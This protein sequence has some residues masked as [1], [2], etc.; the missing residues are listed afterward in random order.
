MNIKEIDYLKLLSK[1]CYGIAIVFFL[2]G[3]VFFLKEAIWYIWGMPVISPAGLMRWILYKGD[4][5]LFF[6]ILGTG[7]LIPGILLGAGRAHT[8][9]KSVNYTR[10]LSKVCFGIAIVLWISSTVLLASGE[11]LYVVRV[12]EF[13]CIL[14]VEFFVL[15]SILKKRHTQVKFEGADYIKILSKSCLLM[16]AV[17]GMFAMALLIIGG[18]QY[19]QGQCIDIMILGS[20]SFILGR[21]LGK[22]KNKEPDILI[23]FGVYWLLR[24]FEGTVG[25]QWGQPVYEWQFRLLG[26][27]GII[28]GLLTRKWK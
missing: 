22:R 21:L 4:R 2:G 18:T 25:N 11:V 5:S 24:C 27:L 14:G 17:F 20:W 15:G 26:V 16:A 7:F 9:D 6:M 1:V 19:F 23:G 10:V 13:L 12:C 3:V 28:V 8:E